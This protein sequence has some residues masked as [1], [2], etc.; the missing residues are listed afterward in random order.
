LVAGRAT[1]NTDQ[2]LLWLT[3]CADTL[4]DG[5]LEIKQGREYDFLRDDPRFQA[6]YRRIGFP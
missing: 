2:P 4:E 5:V 1:V 3:R 6:L